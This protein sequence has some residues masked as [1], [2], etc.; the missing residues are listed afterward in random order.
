LRKNIKI[1]CILIN[2]ILG[3]ATLGAYISPHILPSQSYVIAFLGLVFPILLFSNFL[4]LIFW[5]FSK[6]KLSLI[7]AFILIIGHTS[8]F[9]S[10]AFNW[11]EKPIN[12]NKTVPIKIGTYNLQFSKPIL[13]QDPK[14]Q[15]TKEVEFQSFL[16]SIKD[17]AILGVQECGTQSKVYLEKA[18]NFPYKY[19]LENSIVGIYSKYPILNKGYL[20]FGRNDINT[21]LWADIK[22]GKDTIRFYTT[23]LEPNRN[24]G[25]VP[26]KIDQKAKERINVS[27]LIGILKHY[28]KFTNQR[29]EQAKKIR[30]HQRESPYPSIICGDFNDPPQS[31]VYSTISKN[32]KDAFLKKGLGIGTT[33]NSIPG[34]RIDY[35][36][37]DSQ[38]KILNYKLYKNNFSD[39][40]PTISTV[41][42]Q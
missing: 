1:G 27:T 24:T 33:I 18:I 21:C 35:I 17:V 20:D 30:I 9:K 13:S 25:K 26:V 34:L 41:A 5:L 28:Q 36:L 29:N 6:P 11:L 16:Q 40:Y 38:L 19:F 10:L 2:I 37:T 3:L 31:R 42:I 4:F 22:I 32:L 39:H 15:A 7:S 14:L 12:I 8:I 23:H